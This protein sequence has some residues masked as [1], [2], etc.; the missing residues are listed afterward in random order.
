M[1]AYNTYKILKNYAT[2]LN[3]SFS[4]I[5]RKCPCGS[6]AILPCLLVCHKISYGHWRHAFQR[7]THETDLLEMVRPK[8]KFTFCD[9]ISYVLTMRIHKAFLYFLKGKGSLLPTL[10]IFKNKMNLAINMTQVGFEFGT[11]GT[12]HQSMVGK[13]PQSYKQQ[14]THSLFVKELIFD[15]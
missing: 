7:R 2:N 11:L 5:K 8:K 13:D 10:F 3:P 4:I 12:G 6:P 14:S 9:I 1:S 15:A